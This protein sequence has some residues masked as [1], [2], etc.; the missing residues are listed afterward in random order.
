MESLSQQVA[1]RRLLPLTYQF[2]NDVISI[3][4]SAIVKAVK[5]SKLTDLLSQTYY[6]VG[7]ENY[8]IK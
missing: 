5:Q 6:A 1:V 3:N 4:M 8:D 2:M 7:Y